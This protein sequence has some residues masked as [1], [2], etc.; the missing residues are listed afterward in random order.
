MY[1]ALQEWCLYLWQ[2]TEWP[3]VQLSSFT[4]G[5]I[6]VV[7]LILAR[8]LYFPP[9][10]WC[11]I[12]VKFYLIPFSFLLECGL[13]SVRTHRVIGGVTAIPHS[14]PWQAL[15][16]KHNR[17]ICGGTVISNKYILTAAHCVYVGDV[18]AKYYKIRWVKNVH[19]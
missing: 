13:P 17:T 8:F 7:S 6:G 1:S 18:K 15:L 5:Y 3:M 2:S 14:W 11:K 4:F 10:I 12:F 9:K 19:I 16:F